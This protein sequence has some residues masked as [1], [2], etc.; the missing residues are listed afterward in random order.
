MS[1]FVAATALG[2]LVL[3]ALS[4]CADTDASPG[5]VDTP[6]DEGGIVPSS[7]AG[8]LEDAGDV[9]ADADADTDAGPRECSKEG[10]CHTVL[11]FNQTLRAV[12]SDGAGTTW[13]TSEQG[14]V[15][16]YDGKTW[17]VHAKLSTALWSIWGSSPTDIW[18]GGD[19]GLFHGVGNT[20]ATLAFAQVALPDVDTPITS[21]WGTSATDVWATGSYLYASGRVVHH[22]GGVGR[23]DGP[24]F[25]LESVS[26]KPIS[27]TRVFGSQA[28]GVWIAGS[29]VDKPGRRAILLRRSPGT[30]D[31][32]E[33]S[34]P[35][36]PNPGGPLEGA[37]DRLYDASLSA[38]GLSVYVLGRAEGAV[39]AVATG[40]SADGG[41]TFTWGFTITGNYKEP[42]LNAV[43]AKSA[44]DAWIAG[45]YGRLRHWNGTEWR[46]S[47]ITNDKYP[48]IAP[49]YA[50][51]G[52]GDDLWFVGDGI[53]LH[54]APSKVEP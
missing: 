44:S 20:S 35:T 21:I 32:V 24:E 16:R 39:P 52:R 37:L 1:R 3:V 51:G 50:M 19:A 17:S 10:F 14:S 29:W 7:D 42:L 5:Q 2:S 40:T 49:L 33:V 31:F 43:G 22:T 8:S 54:R 41:Q 36:N 12:W 26:A 38:D 47:I 13:A 25:V 30:S 15:L 53:A 9:D 28:T 45:D 27:Y 11:P 48:V 6:N 34:L 23:D 18:V 4:A 46:Q